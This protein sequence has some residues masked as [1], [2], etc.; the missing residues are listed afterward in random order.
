MHLTNIAIRKA[1]PRTKPYKLAD[2]GG[3]FLLVRPN[4]GKWWRLRYRFQG[5]EQLLSL[6]TYPQ[7]SL[8]EARNKRDEAKK[9][10][11]TGINPSDIRKAESETPSESFE[12]VAREW[13]NKHR[14]N[15]VETHASRQMQRL[16]NDVFPWI[17]AM[18]I[19]KIEPPALLQVLRRV[20]NRGVLETAHRIRSICGQIFRYAVASGYT[21][22]DPSAD[23][24]D[25][26][27]PAKAH[28][29][30]TITEPRKVGEL[31]RAIDGYS[32][33]A[34]AHSALRLLPLVFVRPGEL[35]HMEW[36]EI[37]GSIW[38]IPA[39]KM[40]LR[41]PHIVPLS[42]QALAIL[43]ELEPLTGSGRYVFPSVRTKDRPISENTINAAL[44]RLGYSK[45]EM[46]GHGFRA[47]ATTLLN[48]QGWHRDAIERQMA[49]AEGNK[50]RA[51]YNYAEHLPMR[52]KMMQAW[53]DYLDGLKTG[54]DVV[55]IRRAR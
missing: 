19:S 44:R 27:P 24:K 11:Q 38:R 15:W 2:G 10:L 50:V 46:T 45:E 36:A 29:Y 13:F 9:Q 21:A 30:A 8:K 5:K 32:G 35:R 55:P 51:A 7:V 22:R 25:A 42:R 53:A 48:E 37:D 3:M 26:L 12:A 16:E 17:G 31:L 18:P 52:E 6:G 49:H 1:K 41:R 40:K 20:E 43:N 14:H 39:E 34:I 4:G 54:A 33:S 23:L 47:I 28:H